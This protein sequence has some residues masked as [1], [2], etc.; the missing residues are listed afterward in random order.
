MGLWGHGNALQNILPCTHNCFSP[1]PPPFNDILLP[2][3]RPKHWATILN[4]GEGNI[5]DMSVCIVSWDSAFYFC[6]ESGQECTTTQYFKE[7][8][9]ILTFIVSGKRFHRP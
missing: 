8:C 4:W 3:P 5:R 6:I 1:V 7:F 9:S 2:I